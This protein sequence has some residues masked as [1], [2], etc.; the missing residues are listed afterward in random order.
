[1]GWREGQEWMAELL[2]V[3]NSA[4]SH[5]VQPG[6]GGFSSSCAI[7]YPSTNGRFSPLK[8]LEA[9]QELSSSFPTQQKDQ[10]CPCSCCT[11]LD[12]GLCAGMREPGLGHS[13]IP[14]LVRDGGNHYPDRKTMTFQDLTF[15]FKVCLKCL[16]WNRLMADS[17][18]KELYLWYQ[19][20]EYFSLHIWSIHP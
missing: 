15:Q 5:S 1:M 3:L 7:F 18:N 12:K 6:F 17:P 9:L 19:G 11:H 2:L 10:L 13:K 20:N 4:G 16:P 14:R 8:D